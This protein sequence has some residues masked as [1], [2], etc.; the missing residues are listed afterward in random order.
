MDNT[1]H[2]YTTPDLYFAAFLQCSGGKLIKTLRNGQRCYFAF[3]LAEPVEALR[4]A[5]YGGQ[6]EVSAMHYA[7][8]LK[9]LKT[10]A[11]SSV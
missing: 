7:D 9:S 11:L 2:S 4:T 8:T 6:G 3:S 1:Q 10:L 5:W